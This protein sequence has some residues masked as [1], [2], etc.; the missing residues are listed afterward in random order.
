[1]TEFNLQKAKEGKPVRTKNGYPARIICFD[2]FGDRPLIALVAIHEGE[3]EQICP[4][5][6]DGK[7]E[8]SR[9]SEFDLEMDS[10]KRTG[11]VNLFRQGMSVIPAGSIF[12]SESEAKQVGKTY[13]E[14]YVTT[15]KIEW[16]E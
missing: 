15:V 16:E 3:P 12:E 5:R 7:Y 14:E 6:E 1:M 10:R 11:Y 9:D 4:Y 2:A 8:K 13:G